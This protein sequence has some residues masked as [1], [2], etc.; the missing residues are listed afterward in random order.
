MLILSRKVGEKII[1]SGGIEIIVSEI[2]GG[3]VRIG[4]SA[5]KEVSVDRSEVYE[6]KYNV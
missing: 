6:K 3:Q 2:R 1:I 5:P 4:V